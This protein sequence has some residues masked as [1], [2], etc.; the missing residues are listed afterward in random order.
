MMS[1]PDSLE[2]RAKRRASGFRLSMEPIGRAWSLLF[3]LIRAMSAALSKPRSPSTLTFLP[4]IVR[5]S[6]SAAWETMW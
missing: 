5:P 1:W 6:T 2:P 3:S 4:L